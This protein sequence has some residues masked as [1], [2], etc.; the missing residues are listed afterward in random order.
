MPRQPFPDLDLPTLD[1]ERFVLSESNPDWYTMLVCYRGLHCP[2][3]K[4]QLTNLQDRL[5]KFAELG[6]EAIAISMDSQERA[7]KAREKWGLD[8]LRIA[9]GM[10]EAQ[11]RSAGLY[12]SS[13]RTEQE[14]ERFSEPGLF[15]V[16]PDLTLYFA[17]IQ[18]APFTRPPFDELLGPLH[19]VKEHGYPARGELAEQAG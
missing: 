4:D 12:I 18:T 6:I 11:A 8:R 14:P 9:Y 13:A 15:L 17:S 7:G 2:I 16:E 1:G 3:C 5:D 19:Y 10:S